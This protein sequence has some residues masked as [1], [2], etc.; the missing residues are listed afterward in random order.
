M[1]IA[2]E[3]RLPVFPVGG[4]SNLL[5]SDQAINRMAV[6]LKGSFASF[7]AENGK[8]LCGAGCNLQKFILGA[9][10]M[11]F[12]G[13]EFM[14]GIPGTVGGALKEN[15][16]AGTGR[17]WI[18]DFVE[19]LEVCD[20]GGSIKKI[21]KRAAGF[22]Y[23]TS[24]LGGLII[25]GAEFNLKQDAG[26]CRDRLKEYKDFLAQKKAKQE[27]SKPSAGCIFKNPKDN[28]SAGALIDACGL[29]GKKI[30]GAMVSAKHANFI[31]N[32]KKAAFRDVMDLIELIR[33]KVYQKYNVSLETEVK[34]LK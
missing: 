3:E 24:D 8:I 29:K 28:M 32:V 27:L 4:G 15:A 12:F 21:D 13:L 1:D 11:G 10:D 14:A 23:R 17:P 6:S 16:G 5:V 18:S 20:A 9:I 22:G 19:R 25:L 30:G 7:S 2:R 31:V 26:A 33:E 34:I